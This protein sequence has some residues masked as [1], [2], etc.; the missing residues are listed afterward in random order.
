MNHL[1]PR[2]D[3]LRIENSLLQRRDELMR[4]TSWGFN[5]I[6]LALV[7]AGFATF[8][9]VQYNSTAEEVEE[10]RIPFT[11][12]TW[13]SATRN[14]RSEEYERQLQPYE[15]ETGYGVP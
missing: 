11:P 4:A 9:Y 13:Y 8:L 7:L 12:T 10:K 14:V 5:M 2:V 15:A 6:L 3:L 1:I